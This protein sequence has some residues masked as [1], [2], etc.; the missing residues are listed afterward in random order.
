MTTIWKV[1]NVE[2]VRELLA[3]SFDKYFGFQSTYMLGIIKFFEGKY[4]S[5]Y[6]SN[7]IKA[8]NTS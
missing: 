1:N 5:R 8:K 4:H 6:V 2:K 7:K 3:I